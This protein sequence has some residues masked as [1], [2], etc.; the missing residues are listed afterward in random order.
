MFLTLPLYKLEYIYDILQDSGGLKLPQVKEDI[1]AKVRHFTLAIF[2]QRQLTS[3]CSL[4]SAVSC[5]LRVES[6]ALYIRNIMMFVL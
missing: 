4:L 3:Y 5:V 6:V 1:I 2:T